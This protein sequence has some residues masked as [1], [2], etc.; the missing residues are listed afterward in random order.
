ME[1]DVASALDRLDAFLER[2]APGY[3]TSSVLADAARRISVDYTQTRQ[4]DDDAAASLAYLAH[5]GP[6]AVVALARAIRSLPTSS[7]P[8]HVVDI[9]A[10]S[11]ASALAWLAVGAK[12]VTLVERSAK[13]LALA[14][15]LHAGLPVELRHASLFDASAITEAS[16]LS[17]SFVVGELP[18]DTDLIAL[19]TRLAPKATTTVL[20]DAGD[21]PRARR[22]QQLRDALVVTDVAV[23]GPCPHREPCPALVRERDWCHDRVDKQLPERLARF[24]RTVGRDDG[25][26]SLSWLSWSRGLTAAAPA[27]IVVIGEPRAEKGR[28]R[29]PICGP[30]GLRFLQVL[31]R[32]KAAFRVARELPRGHRLPVP[33]ALDGET[34]HANSIY[35]LDNSA[36]EEVNAVGASE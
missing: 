21:Q 4:I 29:V 27:G 25:A 3:A 36:S 24:A 23:H 6:R 2:S 11:G 17:A 15:Q 31:K 34:L 5:F 26:M 9:G 28:V 22:L 33:A 8:R 30:G 13:A 1:V 19:F 32:D 18:A 12:K 10:G 20:V 7:A 16:H 35:Q 14:K